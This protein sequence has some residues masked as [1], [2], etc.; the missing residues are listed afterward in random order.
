MRRLAAILTALISTA[1]CAAA[2]TPSPTNT[3]AAQQPSLV[4]LLVL[5]QFRADYLTRFG[6]QL[7]G[8][9]GRLMRDGAWFTN[10]HHD[11]GIAETAPGHATLLSGRFPRSTGIGAN[12]IGVEDA[13][14]PM[15]DGAAGNGA[16]PR[17]FRGTTL[18]DWLRT[19]DSRS[20]ALSVSRKDR[21]AILPLGTSKQQVYWYS[22]DGRFV[23]S[24]YYADA[25]PEWVKKFNARRIPHSYAGKVWNPLL[26]ASEYREKDSVE[27]ESE[28]LEFA[29]PHPMPDDTARATRWVIATPWMDDIIAAFAL[30]GLQ[31]LSL[32]SGSR[33]D[34]LS[35]SLSTTDAMGHRFGPDSKEMHDQILQ[36]DRALSVF[37]DSLY[38]LRKPE[39]VALVLTSDHGVASIP[40]LA[41]SIKP[42]PVRASLYPLLDTV[43]A[44]LVARKVNPAAIDVDQ[45]IV[46]IDRNEFKRAKVDADSVL[47]A[48]AESARRL[49]G[50]A[51]VDRF[52]DLAK[53]DTIADPVA[54]RWLH[55]F[56]AQDGVELIVTLRRG[57]TWGGNVASHVSPYDYDTHVPIIFYGPQFKAGKYPGF[58]RTVDI[59]P[60]LAALL[61]ITP[62]EKLDGVV[63]QQALK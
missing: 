59:A 15:L 32:G 33:T 13:A 27:I 62:S 22:L 23:T 10:A 47:N 58:V 14:F 25:L 16:S 8:G 41:D 36:V 11:H 38:R 29:F 49:P 3:P 37:L 12:R 46:M 48:F 34:V 26:P 63:L 40:E 44:R 53:A 56:S 52:S 1:A 17:R 5:D 28:G 19:R 39:S 55:H 24:R 50:I 45:Q 61:K 9:L 18:V 51:R 31:A 20:Q 43:R 35:V 2:Q 42:K 54:R 7:R 30:D 4:V 21:A 6:P 60:T 57:S